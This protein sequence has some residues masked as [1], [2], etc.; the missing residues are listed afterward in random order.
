M[1]RHVSGQRGREK[2]KEEAEEA[3]EAEEEGVRAHMS[4]GL[5]VRCLETERERERV[6]E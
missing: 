1:L 4:R 3:E 5:C 6:S 2:V